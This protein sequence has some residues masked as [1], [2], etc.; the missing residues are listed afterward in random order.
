MSLWKRAGAIEM[1]WWPRAQYRGGLGK[2]PRSALG[3]WPMGPWQR[4]HLQIYQSARD[5]SYW[6][7]L[8]IL[9]RLPKYY[10]P[11]C[12]YSTVMNTESVLAIFVGLLLISSPLPSWAGR[13]SFLSPTVSFSPT[14]SDLLLLPS[15]ISL[16]QQV[17]CSGT[18]GWACESLLWEYFW[19]WCRWNDVGWPFQKRNGLA[20]HSRSDWLS[21][22]GVQDRAQHSWKP[23]IDGEFAY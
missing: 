1:I 18:L 2:C 16:Y 13:G 10:F 15:S 9:G 5:R 22:N 17:S 20:D 14:S 11:H 19:D 8:I 4:W 23:L 6:T 21:S 7:T 3:F 12:R